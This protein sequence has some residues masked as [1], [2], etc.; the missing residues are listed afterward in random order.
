LRETLG[1]NKNHKDRQQHDFYATPPAKVKNILQYEELNGVILEN[2]CGMGH[3][4]KVVKELYPNNK[5]IATDKYNY[6]YGETGL[7][8]LS[9]DYPYTDNINCIIMNPPFKLIENFVI[10]SLEIAKDKVLLFARMQF[11]E[12][13]SRYIN[14][15]KN[16]PPTK[17]YMYVN[18][19]ACA[20]DG[21]FNKPLSSNMAFAWFVWNKKDK[22]Y[23][24]Y[25]EFVWIRRWD[26]NLKLNYKN[27]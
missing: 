4:A 11:A 2:S 23:G 26:K 15:F 25:T 18:R 6:G 13:E 1:Y 17:I 12:S 27:I 22:N 16:Q 5:I 8:F 21:D 14:I 3:I 20:K 9:D 7:D 19:V 10:K 24:K